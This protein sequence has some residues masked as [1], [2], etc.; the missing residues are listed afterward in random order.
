MSLLFEEL[1]Q[2]EETW[3][4]E[5][6]ELS[7]LIEKLKEENKQLKDAIEDN[8]AST[9]HSPIPACSASKVIPLKFLKIHNIH[10][11]L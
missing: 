8:E 9:N 11:Y 1:E 7:Q 2:I 10:V 4:S 3:H 5:V 6:Q